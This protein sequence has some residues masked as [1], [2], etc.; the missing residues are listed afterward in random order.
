MLRSEDRSFSSLLTYLLT[1]YLITRFLSSYNFVYHMKCT[2]ILFIHL[3]LMQRI[4]Y[5]A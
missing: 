5:R 2:S 3:T 1:Y 4:S